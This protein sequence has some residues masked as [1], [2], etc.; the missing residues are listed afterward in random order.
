MT[1]AQSRGGNPM[2]YLVDAFTSARI[3]ESN[4]S[5][6]LLEQWASVSELL[7]ASLTAEHAQSDIL[8]T[9]R[10]VFPV[11]RSGANEFNTDA[12]RRQ[13]QR[14]EEFKSY[15]DGWNGYGALKPSIIAINQAKRLLTEAHFLGYV[16]YYT[17]CTVGGFVIAEIIKNGRHFRLECQGPRILFEHLNAKVPFVG[18]PIRKLLRTLHGFV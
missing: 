16:P 18:T 12:L 9:Y 4:A 17:I 5:T 13:L 15:D 14:L 11:K 6:M 10:E 3:P 2:T 8:H 7:R 1:Q